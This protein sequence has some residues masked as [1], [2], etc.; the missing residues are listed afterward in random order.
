MEATHLRAAGRAQ[1]GL[2]LALYKQG[3]LDEALAAYEQL[4]TVDPGRADFRTEARVGR[5]RCL[6]QKGHVRDAIHVLESRLFELEGSQ[7]PDPSALVQIYSALIPMYFEAGLRDRAKDVASRG[8]ALAD[9]V[10]DVEHLACLHVNR[11]GLLLNEGARE[12]ALRALGQAEDLYRQLGWH[13]EV[14]KITVARALVFVDRGELDHAQRLLES[15]LAQEEGSISPTDRARAV[16]TLAQIR[17]MQDRAEEGL[18]L[19]REA[20]SLLQSGVPVEAAEANREAGVC[21]HALGDDSAATG[22]WRRALALF[23]E[24][25]QWEEVARLARLLGDH[26]ASEGDVREAAAVYR[27]A[28][29][30]VERVH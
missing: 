27:D 3:K 1:E 19:A 24:A 4:E 2:A 18:R 5:A 30:A 14:V 25:E 26:L 12:D 29:T 9:T 20:I 7:A 11:A 21:A 8:A 28:L 17:R 22:Y 13:S 16:S 23:K 15:A 6:F 10:A